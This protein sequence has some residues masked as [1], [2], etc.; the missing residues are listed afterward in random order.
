MKNIFPVPCLL[1]GCLQNDALCQECQQDCPLMPK[2][3]CPTCAMPC[4]NA[5][6]CA[7]CN[8]QKPILK[9]VKA[10]FQYDFPVNHL[11][12]LLKYKA[13]LSLL[14]WFAKQMLMPKET[15][16][17]LPI[18][19]LPKRLKQRGFNQSALL[20]KEIAKI[21]P[22]IIVK[23]NVLKH[24]ATHQN[25]TGLTKQERI[26]NIQGAFF[27]ENSKHLENFPLILLDD[28]MTTGA[29]L[30]EAARTLQKNGFSNIHAQILA[31][32]M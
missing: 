8:N 27:V 20:A 25:Q 30:N 29:T 22:Q 6:A 16:Y 24:H 3:I 11:I 14:K 12:T 31:R 28:V 26:K 4:V 1:C 13:H 21:N 9:S 2:A 10:L 19:L 17:L 18:P 23:E 7:N 15:S 32:R 5:N